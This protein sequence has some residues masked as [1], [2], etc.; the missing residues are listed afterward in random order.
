MCCFNKNLP[1]I[2]RHP[3]TREQAELV[4]QE[5]QIVDL[6]TTCANRLQ[7]MIDDYWWLDQGTKIGCPL[8]MVVKSALNIELLRPTMKK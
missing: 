6:I 4:E 3:E 1:V 2:K 7:G 5:R 8:V